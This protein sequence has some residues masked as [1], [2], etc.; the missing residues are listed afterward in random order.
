MKILVID[1][2]T[3]IHEMLK[4][5]FESLDHKIISAYTAEEGIRQI[6]ISEPDAIFLDIRLTDKDG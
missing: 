1:D 3:D 2:S 6:V 4:I 5:F